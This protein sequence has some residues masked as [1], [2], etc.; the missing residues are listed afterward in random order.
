MKS[1]EIFEQEWED[2]PEGPGVKVIDRP[3][4]M[5]RAEKIVPKKP[6]TYFCV[7]HNDDHS[8]AEFVVHVLAKYFGHNMEKAMHIMMQAHMHGKSPAGGPYPHDV[9]ESKSKEAMD[10]AR[11]HEHP[12]LITV[13]EVPAD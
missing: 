12:L 2:K 6:K 7:L 5:G 3:P 11:A 8:H 10:E 1:D 13:E 4:E 9:A